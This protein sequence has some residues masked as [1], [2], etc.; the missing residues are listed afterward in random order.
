MA[1]QQQGEPEPGDHRPERL[2]GR[3]QER[4]A[5]GV[6]EALVGDQARVVVQAD[7]DVAE[8]RPDLEQA[9]PDS[10][11]HQTT[12]V[13]ANRGT[14]LIVGLLARPTTTTPR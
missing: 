1:L 9:Q 2:A 8:E 14:S 6:L 13:A 12:A 3:Q 4:A 11:G 10:L 5:D 7:E